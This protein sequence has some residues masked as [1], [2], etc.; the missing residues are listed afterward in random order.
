M[1]WVEVNPGEEIRSLIYQK[2][3]EE[4]AAVVEQMMAALSPDSDAL[5]RERA[6]FD[7]RSDGREEG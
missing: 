2:D 7:R 4:R 5:S 1:S 6:R 3:Q